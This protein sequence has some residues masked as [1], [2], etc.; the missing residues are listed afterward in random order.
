MSYDSTIENMEKTL[1]KKKEERRIRNEA[2]IKKLK[3]RVLAKNEKIQALSDEVT[4][5]NTECA[6]LMSEQGAEDKTEQFAP[7]MESESKDSSAKTLEKKPPPAKK[8]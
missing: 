8:K 2:K 5:L 1:L 7:G 4:A 6:D 3:E